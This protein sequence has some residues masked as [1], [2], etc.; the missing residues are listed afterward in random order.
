[1]NPMLLSNYL[2]NLRIDLYMADH[3]RVELAWRDID[4]TPDYSK[5]YFIT[6]GEGWLKI[7]DQEHRP[8]PGQL[9]LMPE[10]VKQSYSTISE[11]TYTKYWCHFSAYVGDL[12]LFQLVE[13]PHIWDVADR[14]YVEEV[15]ES[16][17]THMN[18]NT[19]H[20]M[21]LA[22]SKLMEL[23]AYCVSQTEAKRIVLR[24]GQTIEKLSAVLDYIH[25]HIEK[26]FTVQELAEVARVHPNYLIRLFKRYLGVPPI[27]YIT[28]KKMDKAKQLLTQSQDSVSAI[29]ER[30]GFSDLFYFSKQ[31][32]KNTGLTPTEYRRQV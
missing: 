2:A 25:L 3:N 10:G 16:V 26:E 30:I 1:M 31:F 4:Y 32:K 8:R 24:N 7:G 9:I 27:Q 18:S 28:R 29:A 22:K 13:L 19:V 12:N 14:A 6:D 20:G 21:L 11:F 5:F 15:M 23:I 17:V